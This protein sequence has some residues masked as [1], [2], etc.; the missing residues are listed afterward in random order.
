MV[1]RD[2]NTEKSSSLPYAEI[3]SSDIEFGL[4]LTYPE[5]VVEMVT[6]YIDL[7]LRDESWAGDIHCVHLHTGGK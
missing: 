5:G 2:E 3:M 7:E 4:F 1:D 6:D